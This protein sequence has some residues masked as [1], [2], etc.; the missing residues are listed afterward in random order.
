[1]GVKMGNGLL[2][3]LSRMQSSACTTGGFQYMD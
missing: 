1:V 3:L 2:P